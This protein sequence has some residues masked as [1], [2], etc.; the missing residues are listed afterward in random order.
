MWRVAGPLWLSSG[1]LSD[2]PSVSEL[3]RQLLED[4]MYPPHEPRKASAEYARTHHHL[5]VELDEPC[6]ICGIRNSDVQKITDP[7]VKRR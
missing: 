4:V 6:W 1:S 5:V 2:S 3:K 7:K